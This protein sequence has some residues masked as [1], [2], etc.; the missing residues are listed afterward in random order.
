MTKPGLRLVASSDDRAL[1]IRDHLLPL[2]RGQGRL[3]VQRDV[4]RVIALELDGWLI[5]H[6]TPFNDLTAEEATSPA[7]RHA[8]EQQ[9]VR[10]DLPYGLEV[11]RGDR[12]LSVLWSDH[13][14]FAVPCFVRGAWEDEALAL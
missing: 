4:V 10:P 8:L 3:Q 13:G 2:I 5:N 12:V 14:A 9:R 1:A 11:W 6:W 7:Y